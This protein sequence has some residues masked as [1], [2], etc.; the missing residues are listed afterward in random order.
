[1]HLIDRFGKPFFADPAQHNFRPIVCMNSDPSPSAL[2][3]LLNE[4]YREVF[5]TSTDDDPTNTRHLPSDLNLIE[6]CLGKVCSYAK[7]DNSILE[8]SISPE[9]ITHGEPL[10]MH[11]LL[12]APPNQSSEPQPYR[13]IRGSPILVDIAH[14]EHHSAILAD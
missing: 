7:H 6:H 9:E 4:D 10:F 14:S 12:M 3:S 1:M 8:V 5:M 11:I 13:E 2:E